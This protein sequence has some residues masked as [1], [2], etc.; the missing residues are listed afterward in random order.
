MQN[1]LFNCL[2]EKCQKKSEKIGVRDSYCT[3]CLEMI[4]RYRNNKKQKHN[5]TKLEIHNIYVSKEILKL[6]LRLRAEQNLEKI[7]DVIIFLYTAY[8]QKK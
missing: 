3:K 1:D 8:S 5:Q 2:C 7:E 6:L 4:I